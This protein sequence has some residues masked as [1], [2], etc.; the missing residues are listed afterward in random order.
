M[1]WAAAAAAAAAGAD[2]LASSAGVAVAVVADGRS[3]SLETMATTSTG[4][5]AD[6]TAGGTEPELEA[7]WVP[8]VRSL[9]VVGGTAVTVEHWAAVVVAVVVAASSTSA[10]AVRTWHSAGAGCQT[11]AAD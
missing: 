7:A 4:T 10:H 9:T 8:T 6:P 3:C 2:D 1:T 5:A 11:A